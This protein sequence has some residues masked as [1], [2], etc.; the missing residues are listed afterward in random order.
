MWS[1]DFHPAWD[2]KFTI[3]INLEMNYW[4]AQPLRLPEISA[5][6]YDLL[7]RIRERGR[8][9]AR[10]MYGA[11]GVRVPPQHGRDGGLRA[12]S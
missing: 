2:S 9:V 7:D 4:P 6:V 3:N 8:E 1:R 11:D 5:P 10:R 12:V